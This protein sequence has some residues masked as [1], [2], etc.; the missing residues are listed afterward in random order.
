MRAA[1]YV[2]TPTKITLSL[3]SDPVLAMLTFKAHLE[4]LDMLSSLPKKLVGLPL[5]ARQ[6]WAGGEPLGPAAPLPGAEA[7][8]RV[9][10]G[11]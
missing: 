4:A 1:L 8:I 7:E 6:S 10:R 2:M 9:A 3:D 5:A 11:V